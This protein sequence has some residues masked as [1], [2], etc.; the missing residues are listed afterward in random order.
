[1]ST[2]IIETLIVTIVGVVAGSLITLFVSYK[3][4]TYRDK[5][6]DEK[7]LKSVVKTV[8]SEIHSHKEYILELIDGQEM[9]RD[10]VVKLTDIQWEQ[11]QK[12]I[13]E[14]DPSAGVLFRRYFDALER[15]KTK[16]FT[17]DCN[18][19]EE[20]KPLLKLADECLERA[21]FPLRRVEFIADTL[22]V[23]VK[24]SSLKEVDE[25]KIDNN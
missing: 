17:H 11:N 5:Q 22:R 23:V 24:E 13:W 6:R 10:L 14:L 12:D 18:L 21:N 2:E 16:Q 7:R 25:N 15:I 8:A 4:D 9:L 20:F 19:E 1:M 3:V